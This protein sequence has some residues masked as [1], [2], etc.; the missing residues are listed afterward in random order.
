MK[1]NCALLI[2]ISILLSGCSNNTTSSSITEPEKT[3]ITV[4]G[5]YRE[6][7]YDDVDTYKVIGELEYAY[8]DGYKQVIYMDLKTAF[9]MVNKE[10]TTINKTSTGIYEYLTPQGAKLVVDTVQDKITITNYTKL[11]V[12]INTYVTDYNCIDDYYSSLLVKDDGSTSTGEEDVILDLSKYNMDIIELNDKAFIPFSVVNRLSFNL[13]HYSPVAFNGT[14]FYLLDL[15]HGYV[16]YWYEDTDYMRSYYE[17]SA[18]DASD[19]TTKFA[20]YNRDALMFDLEHFYGFHDERFL[21]DMRA[22]LKENETELYSNLASTDEQIYSQAV[23]ELM[24]VVIGDCHTNAD[25]AGSIFSTGSVPLFE[26]KYSERDDDLNYMYWTCYDNREA[27]LKSPDMV[28]KSGNTAIISFDGF[29]HYSGNIKE[30]STFDY[31]SVDNI[32]S[33]AMM[34]ALMEEIHNDKTIENVVFDVTMNG[35]GDTNAC[36]PLLGLMKKEFSIDLHDTP[37]K[38]TRNLKYRV[39]T[40]L[41]GK[42]DDDDSYEGQYNFYILTSNYSFS[43]AN[44]FTA[45]AKSNGAATIIGQR[46]G[47]G[48]CFVEYTCTPDGKPYRISSNVRLEVNGKHVDDG[49]PVDYEI[50]IAHFYDDDYLYNFVNNL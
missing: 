15:S 49:I 36:I 21:P 29:V 34:I 11:Y 8:E 28:R 14:A 43:C 13:V 40:N 42:F 39:D 5:E 6:P 16:E 32:D 41:D 31:C 47:G 46:S 33:F 12:F 23:Y 27:A 35:G 24:Q 3:Y 1:R 20:E 50:D 45:A 2:L 38:M 17:T 4:M 30:K 26:E 10:K 22:Y 9:D 19:R 37:S 44:L 7:D 18:F 25:D 48:A